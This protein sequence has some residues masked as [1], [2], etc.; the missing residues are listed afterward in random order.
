MEVTS[1]M[2]A[3]ENQTAQIQPLH[4]KMPT[5]VE[6]LPDSL[7]PL[8]EVIA[9]L[10]ILQATIVASVFYAFA[11]IVRLVIFRSLARLSVMTSTL[12]DD[13]ILQ[14][15]RK[16][17]FVT[18]IYFGLSLAVTTAQ[19]PFGTQLIVKLLLSLI[20]VSWMLGAIRISTIVLDTL[21]TENKYNLIEPRTVPLIDLSVKLITILVSGY[22]LLLIWGINPVGWLAS[23]GIVGIAVGFAAKDSLANLF[24]GFFI[25]ADAPYKLG[26]YINLDTGERGKVSAIGLRSTRLLT[27]ADVEIT[28]PN[29]VIANAKIINESGGPNLKM[30]VSIAVGV[31]Y[32]TDLDRLC[33]VLIDLAAAHQEVCIDPEPRMRLRGFGA[34]S[35]D[36]DLLVW[37]E[38]PEYK[39]RISHELYMRIYKTLQD[40]GIEIPFSKQD[41]YI[42]ELPGNS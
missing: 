33:E 42:K 20:V 32:G 4:E 13:H 21:G 40:E 23:A 24:S 5:V 36:F 1:Q 22:I 8:W 31:A 18:V 28:I 10:P 26:D 11:L 30:R 12:A 16:P 27:R 39:G 41:L 7:L 19:L 6:W 2:A 35:V 34:S 15:M 3:T 25:V 9:Q 17:V 14:H 38:H 37:I 29:G